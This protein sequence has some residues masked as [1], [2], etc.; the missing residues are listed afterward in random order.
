MTANEVI[1]EANNGKE[2]LIEGQ[3]SGDAKVKKLNLETEITTELLSV[4]GQEPIEKKDE[5]K[6]DKQ[7]DCEGQEAIEKND[8]NKS[9][10]QQDCEGQEA[11]EKNDENKSDK[12]QECK[13][14]ESNN[15]HKDDKNNGTHINTNL[16]VRIAGFTRLT[17]ETEEL[18]LYHA[19]FTDEMCISAPLVEM[20]A[21]FDDSVIFQLKSE[22]DKNALQSLM[23]RG[24][25]YIWRGYKLE[26]KGVQPTM[27]LRKELGTLPLDEAL[28]YLFPYK[29]ISYGKQ[30][31][32]KTEIIQKVIHSILPKK[33]ADI[34]VKPILPMTSV[35]GYD[36]HVPLSIEEETETKRTVCGIRVMSAVKSSCIVP[37]EQCPNV[38][39]Q[40]ALVAKDFVEHMPEF[41]FTP[42][43]QKKKEGN[44][45]GM[46][47]QMTT[48]CNFIMTIIVPT[49]K[50]E[51]FKQLTPN[52]IDGEVITVKSFS[53]TD[54]TREN[55]IEKAEKY[56]KNRGKDYGVMSVYLSTINSVLGLSWSNEN[57]I[58]G[59]YH[60]L[61]DASIPNY[62]NGHQVQVMWTRDYAINN[63]LMPILNIIQEW[64]YM[65][66]TSSI[67]LVRT[68]KIVACY[69]ARRV[70]HITMWCSNRRGNLK[71][72]KEWA[73]KMGLY[74]IEFTVTKGGNPNYASIPNT[75]TA[76]VFDSIQRTDVESLLACGVTNIIFISYWTKDPKSEYIESNQEKLAYVLQKFE[77]SNIFPIDIAP[78]TDRFC[79]LFFLRVK[80]HLLNRK[81]S[82]DNLNRIPIEADYNRAKRFK[83]TYF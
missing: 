64:G 81:R 4:N 58:P 73:K 60:I 71:T 50:L 45:V 69:L 68:P 67:Y 52:G 55:M 33:E 2:E 53:K 59:S 42:F 23:R 49:P 44:I 47:L 12:Q 74:N 15:V 18:K 35:E 3:S 66:S 20:S 5:S 29:D 9:D 14:Q 36:Y 6:S 38:P 30:L 75:I 48:S 83:A 7:Q 72:M 8:K 32:E 39:H 51:Q 77:I 25:L 61:G 70:E 24:K 41:G 79:L 34:K 80:I 78:Y 57:T 63:S 11:I 31:K 16:L 26:M 65:Y 27:S 82:Y 76:I 54:E 40:M 17:N 46:T 37:I 1:N 43:D 13:G 28:Q 19:F 10:K 21:R 22:E 56:Y 62:Y